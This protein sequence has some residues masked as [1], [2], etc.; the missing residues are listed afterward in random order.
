MILI[1]WH[2]EWAAEVNTDHNTLFWFISIGLYTPGPAHV[3][4]P[5]LINKIKIW[6]K[7]CDQCSFL[8]PMPSARISKS[9]FDFRIWIP[10]TT[11]YF[12][13]FD[14][15][16]YN[17][18]TIFTQQKFCG[19]TVSPQKALLWKV[20]FQFS[21]VVWLNFWC[22]M[23]DHIVKLAWFLTVTQFFD[24]HKYRFK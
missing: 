1:F 16:R 21:L 10:N 3:V 15:N 17:F 14:Y 12:N 8:Q 23:F 18:S 6:L 4:L 2:S 24:I 11:C 7:R 20:Q 9:I 13:G 5:A 19:G 22:K